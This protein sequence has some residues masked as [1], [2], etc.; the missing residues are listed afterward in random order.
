[1]FH[2]LGTVVSADYLG[3][4]SGRYDVP[5]DPRQSYF[6]CGLLTLPL[7]IAGF[8]RGLHRSLLLALIVPA[9]C[10]AVGPGAGLARAAAL[11]PAFRD[12]RAPV[13]IWF[14]AA[15]GIALAAS[16]GLAWI[17]ERTG[18]SR[19]LY[20]L[21]ILAVTDLWFW[22]FYKNPMVL[23][24]LSFDQLYERGLDKFRQAAN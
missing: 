1:S 8:L 21:L 18:R 17:I 9:L 6:Y 5:G 11:I 19:L 3:L 7:A 15:L 14:V 16:S 12:A 10:Y 23:A 4:I 20:V 24:H 22:N 13:E 2:A